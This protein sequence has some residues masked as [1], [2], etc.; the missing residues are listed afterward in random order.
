MNFLNTKIGQWS[1]RNRSKI[2]TGAGIASMWGMTVYAV[3]QTPK[4]MKAIE[5]KKEELKTDKLTLWETV[6]A[7]WMY[8]I[9]PFS[10]GVGGT[11]MIGV[12]D[13]VQEKTISAVQSSLSLANVA[14]EEFK[15]KVQE[16]L[17]EEEVKQIETE[18]DQKV[19]E[20]QKTNEEGL[21]KL[22]PLEEDNS[23]SDEDENIEK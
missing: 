12:S 19:A 21:E 15:E 5:A 20:V 7:T 8:Y 11:A 22:L 10:I 17:S 1:Y 4:A 13:A 9:A 16:K 14:A 18:V 6:K 3:A 2:L 23:D